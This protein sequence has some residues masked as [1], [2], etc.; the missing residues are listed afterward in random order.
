[1]KC[2]FSRQISENTQL[3]DFMKISALE[4]KSHADGQTDMSKLTV[5]LR[6]FANALK[7]QSV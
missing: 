7:I 2:V 4:A 1:M 6:N 5:A 3:S